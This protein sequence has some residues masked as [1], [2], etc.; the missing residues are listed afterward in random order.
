MTTYH[1]SHLNSDGETGAAC[2]PIEAKTEREAIEIFREQYP[3]RIISTVGEKG[4]G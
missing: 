1:I 2:K 3:E 4:E